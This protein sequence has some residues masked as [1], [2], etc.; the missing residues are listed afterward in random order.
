M[1][2]LGLLIGISQ[3]LGE[4]VVQYGPFVMTSQREIM[5]AF[6]DFQQGKNGFERA[7]GW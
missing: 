3:P 7:P 4:P 5:Q 1:I 6:S 2:S